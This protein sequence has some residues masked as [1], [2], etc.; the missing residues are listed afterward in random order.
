MFSSYEVE[1]SFLE[2]FRASSIA[3]QGTA[4]EYRP[5]VVMKTHFRIKAVGGVFRA[6]SPWRSPLTV[7]PWP[8]VSVRNS[9][10]EKPVCR[11]GIPKCPQ[12]RTRPGL[13]VVRYFQ[14]VSARPH[15]AVR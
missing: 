3:Y 9:A 14:V 15:R 5:T 12:T 6:N 8:G 1:E 4:T 7:E 10:R 11:C 2:G 13:T